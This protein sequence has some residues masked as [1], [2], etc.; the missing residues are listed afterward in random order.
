MKFYDREKEI[1]ELLRID[2]LAVETAQFTVLMGRRRTGK[3]TLMIEAFKDRL[4]LYFFIG[5]K[6][7]QIQCAEF[8]R[9]VE[10]L[11]GLHIHGRVASFAALLEEILIFSK[12]QKVTVIIDEFQRLAEIDEGIISAVQDVWDKHQREA[13]VHLIACGSIYNMMKKI[14]EDRK[15]PLFGRKTARIDLKPFS[16]KVLREILHDYNPDYTSEDLLMLYAI[17]GGVAKYVAQL[18]DDGC[19]TWQDM[20]NCVCRPSSIF[21]E[22]GT[23]LLVGEF[24]RKFQIYYSILQL[25]ASGMNSQSAIDGIIQ[26]NTGRYLDTLENEYSLVRKFRPMWAKPNSQGVKFYIDD[27]FLMFWFRFI[28]S[29]RSMIELGKYNLLRETIQNEYTQYSGIVLER[30][31]RQMYGEKERVTEVSHWW[32]SKGEN[33]ID[34]IAV[35]KI[36][37]RAT[38]A[39]IKRNPQK[40]NPNKLEEKYNN[41]KSHLRGYRVELI[42]LS[43]EDMDYGKQNQERFYSQL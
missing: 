39:E 16:T 20:L 5:K 9:Q 7:E 17:T 30:Y 27:N 43:M 1:S 28:E 15:E 25:I 22:E 37:R 19:K 24:G 23:E 13:H 3:T 21:L 41:I 31:F 11:L 6:A 36:D 2:N 34:L 33:E 35:E 42:G 40:F 26:K 14:F 12:Q 29:N 38:V 4:Y 10:Q 18:M 8:Q 32:D